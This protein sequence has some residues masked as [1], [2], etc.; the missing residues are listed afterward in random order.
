MHIG[1]AYINQSLSLY[2]YPHGT[3]AYR[4]L[5]LALSGFDLRILLL[6][7]RQRKKQKFSSVVLARVLLQFYSTYSIGGSAS[8]G[9]D[10][11]DSVLPWHE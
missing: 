5:A 7:R 10:G 4:V 6:L 9:S 3:C 11:S 2:S 1:A 8:D